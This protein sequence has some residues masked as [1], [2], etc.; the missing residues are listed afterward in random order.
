[1]REIGAACDAGQ[2]V[3]DGGGRDALELAARVALGLVAKKRR[4]SVLKSAF[5]AAAF[6]SSFCGGLKREKL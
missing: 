4:F 6:L 5:V 3:D 2:Y 1:M